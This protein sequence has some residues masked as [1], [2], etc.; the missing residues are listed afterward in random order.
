MTPVETSELLAFVSE[1]CPSE[2]SNTMSAAA[3]HP[4]VADL[5]ATDVLTAMIQLARRQCGLTPGQVRD[6]VFAIRGRRLARGSS[7]PAATVP[8][9]RQPARAS[10]LRVACPW[11]GAG[12]GQRCTIPGS[13]TRLR[14]AP[15][16][17]IRLIIAKGASDDR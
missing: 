12:P 11:C 2:N 9:P 3:W 17:P 1:I 14:K 4:Q 16:H 5:P 10:A 13:D 7:V 8:R 6:E 15:A